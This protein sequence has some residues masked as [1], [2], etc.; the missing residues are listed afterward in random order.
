MPDTHRPTDFAD[1]LVTGSPATRQPA[2]AARH[3]QPTTSASPGIWPV[4]QHRRPGGDDQHGPGFLWPFGLPAFASWAS[5][6]RQ[7]TGPSS[8]S[9]YRC[10]STPDPVGVSMFHTRKTRLGLGVRYTPGTAVSTRPR[11]L[12][13]RRLPHHN[14]IS[15]SARHYHPTRTVTLTESV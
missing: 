8:R 10:A 12:H 15:L 7:G 9:A 6:T 11:I 5:V 3:R 1:A 4:I 2:F 14:G 13:D